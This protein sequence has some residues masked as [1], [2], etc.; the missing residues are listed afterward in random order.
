MAD[1]GQTESGAGKCFVQ[2]TAP[3]ERRIA[4][5]GGCG[6][7]LTGAERDTLR[8]LEARHG[9]QNATPVRVFPRAVEALVLGGLRQI[10]GNG[11][12]GFRTIRAL[13]RDR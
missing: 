11:Y 4:L 8:F 3:V 13:R 10:V 2:P 1:D 7:A 12:R 9:R 6:G 5:F